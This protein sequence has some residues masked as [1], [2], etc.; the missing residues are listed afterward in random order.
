MRVHLGLTLAELGR[1]PEAEALL[2]EAVPKLP[3]RSAD[4]TRA[5]RFLV[6]FYE[7]WERSQPNQGYAARAAEWRQRLE[8]STGPPAVR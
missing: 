5:L 6:H 2:I 3:P 7:G 8:A 4:T 1:R